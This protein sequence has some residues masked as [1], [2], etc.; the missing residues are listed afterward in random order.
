M[1]YMV[2]MSPHFHGHPMAF[3]FSKSLRVALKPWLK[4]SQDTTLHLPIQEIVRKWAFLFS[5]TLCD[6]KALVKA[7]SRHDSSLTNTRDSEITNDLYLYRVSSLLIYLY[8][9]SSLLISLSIYMW[10]TER[11][12][13][14]GK[15]K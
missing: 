4:P 15:G 9:V 1:L 3:L 7:I 2:L 5:K 12:Q 8:I 13:W 6:P 11:W 14:Q 10:K